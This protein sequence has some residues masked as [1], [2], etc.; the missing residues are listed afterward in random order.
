MQAVRLEKSEIKQIQYDLSKWRTGRNR[1]IEII[2]ETK[3]GERF[4]KLVQ[5]VKGTFQSLKFVNEM[6]PETLE[7]VWSE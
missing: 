1:M 4:E 2:K 5:Y 3:Q 7:G 6:V